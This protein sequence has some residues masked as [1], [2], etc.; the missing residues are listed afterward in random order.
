L[1][2][3]RTFKLVVAYDGT[4]F[5]GWQKQPDQR[6][7]QGELEAALGRVLGDPAITVAGAGRTDAGVHARGQVASFTAA[8]TLP[9]RALP[10]LLCRELPR[11]LRVLAA[12]EQP[13]GFHA[14]HSARARRYAYR[15]L[16]APDLL[17][18]RYAWAPGRMPALAA[19]A[20]SAAPLAGTHDYSAFQAVGS[21]PVDPVCTIVHARWTAYGAPGEAGS[22][23]TFDV[24]AD[25]FLY[26]MVR[27]LVGT[28]LDAAATPDPAAHMRTV[29]DSRDRARGGVTAPPA[30]LSLESVLYAELPA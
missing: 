26:H 13:A 28:A 14:R 21:S 2:A 19:L 17:A 4:G 5:H 18:E 16:A 29:L 3:P 7:V 25:H 8:T 11:D 15:L 24:M 20:A 10:P 23:A 6:T 12:D 22:G 9:A 27:N 1:S 30:G